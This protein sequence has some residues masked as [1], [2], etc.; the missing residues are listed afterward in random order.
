MVLNLLSETYIL[1]DKIMNKEMELIALACVNEPCGQKTI[2]KPNPNKK[3]N[4]TSTT[5]ITGT[6]NGHIYAD[7]GLS[8][9]WA[10]MNVGASSPEGYGD[11]YQ[12]GAVNTP[13]NDIYYESNYGTYDK[14]IGDIK[15]T[16]RDVAHVKWGGAWRMPTRAEFDELLDEDNCGWQWTTHNGVEGY[17]VTSKKSGYKGNSIFLPAAGYRYGTSLHYAGYGGLYWSS[18]PYEGNIQSACNLDFASGKD[19]FWQLCCGFSV[20]PVA[21][22]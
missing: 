20:R 3:K 6:I 14:S 4:T 13:P 17:K 19:W 11:Y 22:F 12:W 7:L 5:T 15:G 10:T 18:T 21:E 8:V 2:E 16:S 9:K 1:K